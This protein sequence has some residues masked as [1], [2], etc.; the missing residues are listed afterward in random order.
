MQ[1]KKK[2]KK[3][4]LPA[5]QSKPQRSITPEVERRFGGLRARLAITYIF[6]IIVLCGCI[7]RFLPNYLFREISG[8]E[9]TIVKQRM[10]RAQSVLATQLDA[11]HEMVKER[12]TGTAS[13]EFLEAHYTNNA[14]GQAKYNNSDLQLNDLIRDKINYLLYVDEKGVAFVQRAINLDTHEEI[15]PFPDA[16]QRQLFHLSDLGQEYLN[17]EI[18]GYYNAREGL[19]LVVSI[20]IRRTDGT[21]SV[22]GAVIA[23]RTLDTRQITAIGNEVACQLERVPVEGDKTHPDLPQILRAAR[24]IEPIVV[25]PIDR[26]RIGG[27]ATIP[28]LN[29]SPTYAL[30]A[31]NGREVFQS[32]A[33]MLNGVVIMVACILIL[34]CGYSFWQLDRLILRRLMLLESDV[35]LIA[36]TGDASLR[37]PVEGD[38]AIGRMEES[39]NNMLESLEITQRELSLSEQSLLETQRMAN[40][41]TWEYDAQNLAIT[42]SPEVFKLVGRTPSEDWSVPQSECRKLVSEEDWKAFCLK[43]NRALRDGKP[44]RYEG[45]LRKADGSNIYI[46]GTCKPVL[47][48]KG[49][50]AILWGSIQDFTEHREVE[51]KREEKRGQFIEQTRRLEERNNQLEAQQRELIALNSGLS[52]AYASLQEATR[53]FQEL[54][55]GLPIACFTFDVEGQIH[56]WNLS[57]EVLTGVS[58]EQALNTTLYE[59]LYLPEHEEEGRRLVAGVFEGKRVQGIEWKIRT[60]DGTLRDV[61]H[62]AYPLH[63]SEGQVVGAISTCVDISAR[64]QMEADLIRSQ[65]RFELAVQGSK[66]GLWEWNLRTDEIYFS[67]QWKK[68]IGYSDEEL[69]NALETWKDRIHPNDYTPMMQAVQ[70]YIERKDREFEV[71]TRLLHK[72]GNYRWMLVRGVALWDEQGVAYRFAGSLTDIT[73]RKQYEVK[74]AEQLVQIQENAL[75]LELQ[76]A[77]LMALNRRLE[78]LATQDGLT[79]VKN[80]RALQEHLEATLQSS[81]R[82]GEPLS[83]MLI[84][85]DNFKQYNDAYGHPA[86]DEVLK[87]V[88][89][90]LQSNARNTDFVARYGGE[91]FAIIMPHTDAVGAF[92][93][94]ERLRK[95]IERTNW[96]HRSVSVSIGISTRKEETLERKQMILEADTAMY[97]SKGAGKNRTTHFDNMGIGILRPP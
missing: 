4:A 37:L 51:R 87:R 43:I 69:P 16:L 7:Y 58:A 89:R 22:R 45:Q 20:P 59:T 77:E 41:G 32:G 86:G 94:A 29:G 56:D 14:T 9:N 38:D 30:V 21:G 72:D 33:R 2:T 49:L 75:A 15:V 73:D 19:Q 8:L 18:V 39:L 11:F 63:N 67:I 96:N 79:G 95:V 40:L 83:F 62:S 52:E 88:A 13:Y 71:E 78:A 47:D 93:F 80:H 65:E 24:R 5:K 42:W 60:I 61:L 1:E 91:E 55:Q 31:T 25:H 54:Y 26:D 97:T 81:L 84:D 6:I 46:Y 28:D 48:K 90:I 23:V 70:R 10:E 44:F 53:R 12:A 3:L 64:K 50:V 68:L 74:V 27:Y 92:D 36:T 35:Q 82:Y 76:R 66:S 34:F 85:V 17:K 57:C